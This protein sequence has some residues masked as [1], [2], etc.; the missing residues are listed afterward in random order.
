MDLKETLKKINENR[1]HIEA[2]FVFSLWK[3]PILYDDY[4]TVNEGKDQTLKDPDAKFYFLLGRAIRNQGYQTFDNIT[5]Y[6]FLESKPAIKEKFE[7]YG[8]WKECESLMSLVSTDNVGA[9]FDKIAKI[10]TLSIMAS[11]YEELFSNV[12]KFDKASNEEV[13]EIFEL[14]NN[15]VALKTGH[16]SKVEDLVIDDSYLEYCNKG[17]DIGT[18]YAKGAPLLNYLTL[19]LP[20][21]DI[22]LLAGHSGTGKSSFIFANMV[23]PIAESGASVAILSNEMQSK[24]YKNML[25]VHI[26][27]KELGYWNITRKKIKMGHFSDEDYAMLKKAAQISKEKYGNIKFVK[28]FENDTSLVLKYIKRLSRSGVS[29]IVFDTMKS[30]DD[31][32]DRMWQKL[33]MSSRKIFNVVSKEQISFVATFQLALY[34]TNQ[35]YLDA[36]CLSNSKQ[37]KEV[38]SELVMMRKLW[39]DEY[40]G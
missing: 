39:D 34:T 8:G 40:S 7:E 13:Y 25:L 17:E 21:G 37:I 35:R 29:T 32:D 11:K 16:D 18:S 36:G 9:Y 6:T 28:L 3:D 24:T 33:L 30:D 26:L 22:Y 2:S 20:I 4:K 1:G 5:V 12:E 14:L 23:L 31:S 10:N 27:T 38:V 19:G 15:S